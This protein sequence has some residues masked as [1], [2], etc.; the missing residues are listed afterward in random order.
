MNIFSVYVFVKQKQTKRNKGFNFDN[1]YFSQ[2]LDDFRKSMQN[3]YWLSQK[4]KQLEHDSSKGILGL[5]QE[6]GK[7][8]FHS[9]PPPPCQGFRK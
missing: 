3:T 6:G 9:P 7:H 5:S 2:N 1:K 4:A 8:F